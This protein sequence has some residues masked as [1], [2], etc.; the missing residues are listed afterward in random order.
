MVLVKGLGLSGF[1]LIVYGLAYPIN[2]SNMFP[3]ACFCMFN[4]FFTMI[5]LFCKLERVGPADPKN[6]LHLSAR[7]ALL[8]SWLT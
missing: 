6:E 4:M 1:G 2:L 8:T 7:C 3:R 5:C